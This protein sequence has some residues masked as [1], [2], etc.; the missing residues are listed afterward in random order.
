V[1]PKWVLQRFRLQDA[2][3][4]LDEGGVTD[5]AALAA[6][7]GWFDQAH[8]TRDFPAV[9]RVPPRA[10]ATRRSAS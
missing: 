1:G 10:Y 6:S 5:L 3:L 2:Q 9:V 4:M 8:F 7:L